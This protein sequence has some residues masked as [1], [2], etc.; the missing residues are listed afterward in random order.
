M[1]DWLEASRTN[2]E[3]AAAALNTDA[4]CQLV[5]QDKKPLGP[6][7]ATLLYRYC[8]ALR[9]LA[10]LLACVVLSRSSNRIGLNWIGLCCKLARR[11]PP[12]MFRFFVLVA[13][14]FGPAV[15]PCC[16]LSCLRPCVSWLQFPTLPFWLWISNVQH[17]TP[18]H[19]RS[20][21]DK[22][23]KQSTPKHYKL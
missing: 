11:R 18:S 2:A 22:A 12:F 15:L 21:H 13:A 16:I 23:S 19:P 10:C 7:L 3:T 17:S 1:A 14:F 8:I 6:S 5:C 4:C 9:W 20:P